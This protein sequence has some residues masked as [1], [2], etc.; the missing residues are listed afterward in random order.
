MSNGGWSYTIPAVDFDN[1]SYVPGGTNVT[2]G[3]DTNLRFV[4]AAAAR[5]GL[6]LFVMLGTN[7][8][9]GANAAITQGLLKFVVSPEPVTCSQSESMVPIHLANARTTA[10][11]FPWTT[12]FGLH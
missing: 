8:A 2:R 6:G 12:E 3:Y 5:R 10:G 9:C 4:D 1:E 7:R 11:V